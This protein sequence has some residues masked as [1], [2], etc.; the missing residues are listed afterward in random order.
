MKGVPAP[1]ACTGAGLE[2]YRP[3]LGSCGCVGHKEGKAKSAREK[4]ECGLPNGRA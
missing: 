1:G 4:E 3:G 2:E